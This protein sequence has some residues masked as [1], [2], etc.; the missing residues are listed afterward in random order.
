MSIADSDR[1]IP[2]AEL[3]ARHARARRVLDELAPDAGGLLIMGDT[4][5]LHFAGT[6]AAGALWLPREG[7]A[8]LLARRA[9]DRV[10]AESAVERVAAFRSFGDLAPLC[11]EAGSPLPTDAPVLVDM[12]HVTWSTGQML[13]SRLKGVALASG[14]MV[15]K[16][17]RM[18]KTPWEAA[19]M[20]EA[21]R[22]HAECLDELRDAVSAGMDEASIALRLEIIFREH[23]HDGFARYAPPGRVLAGCVAAGDSGFLTLAFDGPLGAR[24]LGPAMP[25]GGSPDVIWKAGQVLAVDVDF[26][27]QGYCSDRTQCFWAAGTP[28]P[29]AARRAQ[30]LCLAIE[31]AAAAM[32]RPGAAP[33]AIWDMALNMA[34]E[35]GFKDSFMGLGDDRSRFIGHGVGLEADE[36]PPLAARFDLPLE[37]NMI[38]A[39][40]PKIGVPGVGMVG[41]EHSFLVTAD[42]AECLNP[43]PGRDA[44]ADW[45]GDLLEAGRRA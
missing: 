38:L 28:V 37:E 22:R 16:R 26:C 32:L 10:R 29:E 15:V 11:A 27:F 20:R 42:G 33:S 9:L 45:G 17:T 43:D 14:D 13:A 34:V 3:A 41:V 30:D 19:R 31:R 18:V 8:V 25:F 5:L 24:G 4:N 1:R 6:W 21:G 44:R 35:A 23:G 39:L 40:E 36:F 12:G 2:A 7:E